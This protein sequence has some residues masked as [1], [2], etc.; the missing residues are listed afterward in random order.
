MLETF[1]ALARSVPAGCE[2]YVD[3][4][5]IKPRRRW[6][7]GREGESEAEG[8]VEGEEGREGSGNGSENEHE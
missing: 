4:A 2:G 6:E 1:L 3:E 7:K 5:K 8:E